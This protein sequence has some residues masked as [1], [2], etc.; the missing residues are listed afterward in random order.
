M[1]NAATVD[2]HQQGTMFVTPIP[3]PEQDMVQVPV[4]TV[5]NGQHA[6]IIKGQSAG[7]ATPPLACASLPEYSP[8]PS[9]T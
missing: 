8:L 6:L 4:G 2:G 9:S 5:L 3:R 7:P 1:Q